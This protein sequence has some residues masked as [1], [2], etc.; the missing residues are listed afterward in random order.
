MIEIIPNW[1]PI[2]VKFTVGL[3]TGSSLFYLLW[4]IRPD[5]K[6]LRITARWTLWLGVAAAVAAV[7]SGFVAYYTVAHDAASHAV[8]TT[9]RNWGIAVLVV[10]ALVGGWVLLR[11]LSRRSEGRMVA[12]AMLVGFAVMATTAWYGAELVY[13]HGVG[14]E[15]LPDA[16]DHHHHG[17]EEK[18]DH[19]HDGEHEHEHEHEHEQEHEH[20]DTSPGIVA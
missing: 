16:D 6:E 7:A 9:H 15:R 10:F 11:W 5:W 4:A 12:A 18:H 17:D 19:D 14:V 1:H 20:D 3:L 8:M 2:F 13:R